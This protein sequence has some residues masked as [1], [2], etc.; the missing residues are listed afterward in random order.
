MERLYS[1]ETYIF[2]AK[3]DEY[4]LGPLASGDILTQ[5]GYLIRKFS[6][7]I[8][9]CNDRTVVIKVLTQN[10]FIGWGETYGSV[11]P[12]VIS[13]FFKDII[14]DFIKNKNVLEVEKIHDEL[15]QLM[16]VRG[17]WGGFWLDALA[18]LDIALFDIKA[19]KENKSIS[20]LYR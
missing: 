2:E 20:R 14:M 12:K 4:Y 18:A 19:Q 8:Y 9:S 15:Y 16:R 17:Y 1:I 11:A 5:N 6:N 13:E 3:R 7:T 10:G